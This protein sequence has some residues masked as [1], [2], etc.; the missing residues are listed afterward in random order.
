MWAYDSNL[1][2]IELDREAV[3]EVQSVGV[4][5][6]A[7]NASR[8]QLNYEDVMSHMSVLGVLDDIC[9]SV[10]AGADED[11]IVASHFRRLRDACSGD[12]IMSD[13]DDLGPDDVFPDEHAA[14]EPSPST[15]FEEGSGH[16]FTA[17]WMDARWR[18]AHGMVVEELQAL[19]LYKCEADNVRRLEAH[20]ARFKQAWT[21]APKKNHKSKSLG[22][23]SAAKRGKAR[24]IND[25]MSRS[26]KRR[27]HGTLATKAKAAEWEKGAKR[28]KV[29]VAMMGFKPKPSPKKVVAVPSSK[30]FRGNF[31]AIDFDEN[32]LRDCVRALVNDIRR[33]P[34]NS[35]THGC[36]AD[37]SKGTA[38][39]RVDMQRREA[40]IMY[41]N[42]MLKNEITR[43]PASVR[44]VE[45]M[46]GHKTKASSNPYHNKGARMLRRR[47]EMFYRCGSIVESR[48]G[49]HQKVF[50]LFHDD[51]FRLELREELWSRQPVTFEVAQDITV[52]L[53]RKYCSVPRAA[54][55]EK[56]S[57][58]T[59]KD[60]LK[61]LGYNIERK[62]KT[63]FHDNHNRKDVVAY[64]QDDF[65]PRMAKIR[66]LCATFSGP[67]ME[68]ETL[69]AAV[70]SGL[71]KEH[72]LLHQDEMTMGENDQVKLRCVHSESGHGPVP[73]PKTLGPQTM[74]D[75][76]HTV[77]D[78]PLRVTDDVRLQRLRDNPDHPL[79]DMTPCDCSA[80][81]FIKVG[82]GREGHNDADAHCDHVDNKTLPLFKMMYPNAVP[83][84]MYDHSSA[85]GAWAEDALKVICLNVHIYMH[86][87]EDLISPSPP[88]PPLASSFQG[89]PAHQGGR[90][91]IPAHPQKLRR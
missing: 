56:I 69:P 88:C 3:A 1:E 7:F 10:V 43:V 9:E 73:E 49:R 6:S 51:D 40:L 16:H 55:M 45:A 48:R 29:F 59:A 75:H 39:T 53:M 80:A 38:R 60:W 77:K 83:V 91:K 33:S 26:E 35:R 8:L 67:N 65:L 27:K 74:I 30:V 82:K 54:K 68:I 63:I 32:R 64:R 46:T 22:G 79:K 90:R 78:G 18:I 42:F 61:H 62:K 81:R 72:I 4:G 5:A 41:F 52:Q 23:G 58:S 50:T 31:P 57:I 28:R 2:G 25:E 24:G 12:D 86:V 19:F 66:S 14:P 34:T 71:E 15:F 11:G 87:L 13:E 20:K 85:H 44:V 47:G 17:P 21:E 36:R 70:I 76:T 37:G 84:G 89:R